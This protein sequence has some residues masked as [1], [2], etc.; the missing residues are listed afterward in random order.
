MGAP[1]VKSRVVLGHR[2]L[3]EGDTTYQPNDDPDGSGPFLTLTADVFEDMGR[4]ET[5]TVTIEP[6][7]RLN[8][9]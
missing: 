1:L 3:Y 7:D 2:P 6:G 9:E 8:D 5:I 4:P